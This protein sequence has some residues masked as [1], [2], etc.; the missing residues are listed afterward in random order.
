MPVTEPEL[1]GK[2]VASNERP[3]FV[4]GCGWRSGTTLLQR[5]LCSHPEIHLWGENHGVLEH[6]LH[7]AETISG[8]QRVSRQH[9]SDYEKNGTDGWIAMMNPPQERFHCG[10]RKLLESYYCEA[11]LQLGKTRWGFKEVRFGEHVAAF[12]RGLYP[13]ACFIHLVRHPRDCLASARATRT[14]FLKRGLLADTGEAEGFLRHWAEV[15]KTFLSESQ[16][17]D[18]LR[19][20]YEDVVAEPDDAIRQIAELVGVHADGFSRRVFEVRR[21]GWLEREPQR[22]PRDDSLLKEPWLWNVADQFGYTL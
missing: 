21:R 3:I 6:L 17:P 9:Q 5:V 7:A 14:V 8:L 10:L 12:L 22:S 15:G 1:P 4:F 16:K 19:L 11:T 13:R 20:R 2:A 18:V